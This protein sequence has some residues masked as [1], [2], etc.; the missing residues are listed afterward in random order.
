MKNK[1]FT[2]ADLVVVV[3]VIA[4][5]VAFAIHNLYKG[6][7]ANRRNVCVTNLRLIDKVKAL[8]AIREEMGPE[9]VPAWPDLVPVYFK[10]TP[11]CPAGGEYEIGSVDEKPGCSVE[12]H[13]L[14]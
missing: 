12:G 8:W 9:D 7:Q 11:A 5:I 6:R 3:S 10:R 4:L 1:G 2:L 14:P 13:R